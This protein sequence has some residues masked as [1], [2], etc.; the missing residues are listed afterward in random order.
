[1]FALGSSASSAV[2]VP[3]LVKEAETEQVDHQA[4]H[5]DQEDHLG[6]VDGLGLVE[7]LEAL[8]GDGEAQGNL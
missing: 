4:Q 8:D 6:I 2:R 7:P 3:V 5:P 1:M